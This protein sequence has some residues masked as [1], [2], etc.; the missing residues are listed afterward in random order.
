VHKSALCYDFS[1]NDFSKSILT[2]LFFSEGIPNLTT[3]ASI[4][5]PPAAS[6]HPGLGQTKDYAA[7]RKD[8]HYRYLAGKVKEMAQPK[9]E[10]ILALP[11]WNDKQDAVDKLFE[12]IE[13]DLR[14]VEEILGKHPSFG[15]WVERALEEYL[16]SVKKGDSAVSSEDDDITALPVFMDC[17]NSKDG[18]QM[19]PSILGPLKPHQRDGPG[20]MV[21]EWELSAH[22]KTKRILLRQCTRTIAKTLEENDSSRIF[23]HGRK[24][25]GKVRQV[26]DLVVL[27]SRRSNHSPLFLFIQSRSLQCWLLLLHPP[28]SLGTL[29]CIYQMVID[30]ERTVSSLHPTQIVKACLTCKISLKTPAHSY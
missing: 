15:K 30:F 9:V 12:S 16:Q 2:N 28:V 22:K 10:A 8:Y 18:D 5:L 3:L 19:V 17:F 7:Y 4:P 1:V 27:G 25:V 14:E 20:R 24:G 21:E 26:V 11:D 6:P 13:E 23:V 29:S